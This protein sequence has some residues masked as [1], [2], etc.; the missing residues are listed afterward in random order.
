MR[1]NAKKRTTDANAICDFLRKISQPC[2][3]EWLYPLTASN[4]DVRYYPEG[5]SALVT[6]LA[7]RFD[8]AQLLGLGIL[9]DNPDPRQQ[10]HPG[11][12]ERQPWQFFSGSDRRPA[13]ILTQYGF[14]FDPRPP[15][16]VRY[17]DPDFCALATQSGG[18]V[19]AGT[20]RDSLMWETL[21]QAAVTGHGL[22]RVGQEDL[23]QLRQI[24]EACQAATFAEEPQAPRGIA[25][26][27]W[28][29][30]S[31]TVPYHAGSLDPVIQHLRKLD[32]ILHFCHD[33]FSIATI[34]DKQES[35]FHELLLYGTPADIQKFLD[36]YLDVLNSLEPPAPRLADMG[37]AE[38][39]NYVL[40]RRRKA[41]PMP[42]SKES[43]LAKFNGMVTKQYVAALLED[44]DLARDPIEKNRLLTAAL[45]TDQLQA[46]LVPRF[47]NHLL[48][49]TERISDDDKQ[50]DVILRLARA[51]EKMSAQKAQQAQP[52]QA[53]PLAVFP[54]AKAS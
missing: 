38:A 31:R 23:K 16:L 37:L 18:I 54:R 3:G 49:P 17:A 44:A 43:L 40:D 28:S 20:L 36:R 33:V 51:V 53:S 47:V 34:D 25:L 35:S 48:D 11:L 6:Q 50:L 2:P 45:L 29:F 4:E 41:L 42:E 26:V 15:L 30:R 19:V 24:S 10:I 9:R 32:N 27:N 1:R 7:E 12:G 39:V 14:L 22:D 8:R 46:R 21:G 52:P 5:M 13:D